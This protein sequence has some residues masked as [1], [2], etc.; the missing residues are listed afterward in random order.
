M[1]IYTEI[2]MLT[3]GNVPT[4]KV[5]VPVPTPVFPKWGIALIIGLAVLGIIL[6]FMWFQ[7]GKKETQNL[8]EIERLNQEDLRKS[9]VIEKSPLP[10]WLNSQ[11]L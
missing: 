9:E 1:N 5:E 3:F 11:T 10:N 2:E 6:F 4:V 7:R 8:A